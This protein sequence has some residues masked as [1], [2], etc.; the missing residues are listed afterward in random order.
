MKVQSHADFY[1]KGDDAFTEIGEAST[2]LM[3][4]MV[5]MMQIINKV[6]GGKPITDGFIKKW[7][8][9]Q[10]TQ[11]HLILGMSARIRALEDEILNRNDCDSKSI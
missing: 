4:I 8:N 7:L 6:P 5:A 3:F 2:Q 11:M 9:A 10:Q 1:F